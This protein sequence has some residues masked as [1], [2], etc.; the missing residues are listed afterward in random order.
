MSIS[1][2]P[3]TED[4][5]EVYG[6]L[7]K[8]AAIHLGRGVRRPSIQATQL[9]HE[10]W[11]RLADQGWRSRTHFLALASRAMRYVLL[12]EVRARMAG[13]RE[14][15]WL[16]R[17]LEVGAA[18]SLPGLATPLEQIVELNQ[19][20]ERLATEDPR[21]AKVVEMR[22]FGGMEFQEIAEA[23]EVSLMTV[24]RD[25]R[26]SRAWLYTELSGGQ[27]GPPPETPE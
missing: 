26:F 16:R 22:F 15:Q 25:W 9:V 5:Q 23:L 27:G 10:A 2:N 11:I 17:S 13:K 19:A 6:E 18:E 4:V 3:R 8:I 24:K 21:K 12:D 14:G 1:G 20:L 7:R